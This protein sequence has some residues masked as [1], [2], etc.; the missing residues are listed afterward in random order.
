MQAHKW[1]RKHTEKHGIIT[2]NN[3]VFHVIAWLFTGV[4][5]QVT[6]IRP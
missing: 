6:A 4:G 3:C 5:V 1:Q 2:N